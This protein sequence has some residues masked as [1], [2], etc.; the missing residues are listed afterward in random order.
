MGQASNSMCLQH[1]IDMRHIGAVPL[2]AH[3]HGALAL[4]HLS[5]HMDVGY[6]WGT[7]TH[8]TSVRH[9]GGILYGSWL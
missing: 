6:R 9:C 4:L 1:L 3:W 2:M 7:S 8:D 5:L